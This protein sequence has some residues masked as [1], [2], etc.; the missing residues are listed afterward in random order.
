MGGQ[1]FVGRKSELVELNRFLK[2]K[3]ASFIVVK[4]RRRIGKSRLIEEFARKY[5]FHEFIGL[6]PNEK[7]TMQS[8]L[9]DFASQLS[10]EFGLAGVT[11]N[12]WNTL[13]QLLA[14][15]TQQGRVIILL[16]EISWIGSKDPD[17]LAKLKSAWDK[18]FKKNPKLILII[19]GSSS[20][21]VEKNILSSSAFLGRVSYTLTLEELTLPECNLFWQGHN[22]QLSYFEKCKMLS[23]TGGV[24]RY[25]EEI[26]PA[27]TADENISALCF[28]KGGLLTTEFKKIFTDLFGRRSKRYQ[29]IVRCLVGGELSYA[30]VC[31]KLSVEKSGL[32]SEY[33]HD[34]VMSGFVSQDYTWNPKTGKSSAHLLKYRLKDNY[35]RFYLKYI[36]PKM[37]EIDQ[38][39]F[40]F[41]S[42]SNLPGWSAI[43]GLQFE[44]LVLNNRHFIFHSLGIFS[45]DIVIENPFFQNKTTRTKG[46]QI[47]YLIQTRQHVLYVCEIKF[48]KNLVGRKVIDE[49]SEKIARL[50]L[51]KGMSCLPVLI[52]VNGVCESVEDAGYFAK[53]IDFSSAFSYLS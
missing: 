36:E 9:D 43:M 44:N 13:F 26:L 23:V 49:M 41:K 37:A 53:I 20:S 2:K 38:G 35:L 30:E 8:Q 10:L 4:G 5:Q 28:R 48:S 29:D 32:I 34:L 27:E 46:C 50:S 21:W 14:M 17:F 6:L 25:L 1:D 51:P 24:P 7:T 42:L 18:L 19:C 47:D 40:Q 3:T 39:V 22:N 52:H 12:N 15:Q 11:A 45:E 31:A 33:L 16:D